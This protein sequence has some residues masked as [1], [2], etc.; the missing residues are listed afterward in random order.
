MGIYSRA[1]GPGP[2]EVLTPSHVQQAATLGDFEIPGVISIFDE[3]SS[4]DFWFP[5]ARGIVYPGYVFSN[6]EFYIGLGVVGLVL[7]SLLRR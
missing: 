1:W 5:G 6:T 4:G 3:P 2:E 7:I